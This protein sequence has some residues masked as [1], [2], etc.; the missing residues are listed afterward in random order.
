MAFIEAFRSSGIEVS[1]EAV[2]GVRGRSKAE[3]IASLVA[4]HLGDG[5]RVSDEVEKI[6]ATFQRLLRESF[7]GS[8][9]PVPGARKVLDGIRDAGVEVVLSTGLDRITADCLLQGLEW[10]H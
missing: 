8:P 2:S 1:D 10:M 6:Y 7:A 3:A 4:A 5:P 9:M